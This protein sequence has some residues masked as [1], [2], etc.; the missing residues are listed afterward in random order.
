MAKKTKSKGDKQVEALVHRFPNVIAW[1]D[2]HTHDNVITPMPDPSGLTAG[3]WD[4]GTAA[5]I[6]WTS[7][8]W[9]VEIAH[10]TDGALSI[11]CSMVD[12]ASHP[13]PGGLVGLARLASINRELC[14]N[15][16]QYGFD[17]KGPGQPSD[18][19]VELFL[20]A[21]AWVSALAVL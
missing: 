13:D 17:S 21:P 11:I 1:V 10:R 8:S 14:A 2:G 20:P 16:P 3:F 4:I 6:D 5:H 18:R 9:I 19:N 7:Q 15:D 12:H